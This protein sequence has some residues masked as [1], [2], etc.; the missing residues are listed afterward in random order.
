MAC[1][2]PTLIGS[3]VCQTPCYSGPTHTRNIGVC[4]AGRPVCENG[5]FVKCD[6]EQLP[7][8]EVCDGLDNDCDLIVDES[9]FAK[10]A[11]CGTNVGECSKGLLRCRGGKTACVGSTYKGPESELCDGLDND[12][13]GYVD[14]IRTE[15]E[16]CYDG[17]PETVAV[18]PCHAGVLMCLGGRWECRNQTLPSIEMCDDLDNDC[19]GL[20]DDG[21]DPDNPDPKP[22]DLVFIV[23]TSGSMRGALAQVQLAISQFIAAR[24][25]DPR[26]HYWLIELGDGYEVNQTCSGPGPKPWP[27]CEA[28]VFKQAMQDLAVDGGFEASLDAIFD[29][30]ATNLIT[31][32]STD[33][34]RHILLFTDEPGQTSVGRTE[35]EV[36]TAIARSRPIIGVHAFVNA[37]YWS[38]FPGEDL[39]INSPADLLLADFIAIAAEVC[40]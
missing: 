13:D 2:D 17:P 37:I 23:D 4:T 24:E 34:I 22:I 28:T 29:V 33:S 18:S 35:S 11:T 7:S 21:L 16:L 1:S 15:L 5:E 9:I 26:F 14:N 36:A 40:E 27:P 6:G 19:N 12:C 39:D 20:V 32:T 3:A 30:A 31:W 8:R 10:T 25:H 38:D